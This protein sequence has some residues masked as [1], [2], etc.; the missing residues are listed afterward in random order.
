MHNKEELE[1]KGVADNIGKAQGVPLLLVDWIRTCT[2][3]GIV[4]RAWDVLL[5]FADQLQLHTVAG[6][7]VQAWGVKEQASMSV[8]VKLLAPVA[9]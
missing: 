4:V 8:V 9:G 1:I 5:L 3:A 6:I 2:V 7:V